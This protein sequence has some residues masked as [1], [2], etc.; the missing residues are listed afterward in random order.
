MA[1]KLP[2][3]IKKAGEGDGVTVSA[4]ETAPA[5]T[6][7]EQKALVRGTPVGEDPLRPKQEPK[8]IPISEAE[9]EAERKRGQRTLRGRNTAG[10]FIFNQPDL[11]PARGFNTVATADAE[12]LDNLSRRLHR[13]LGI[14]G[15]EPG[16][17]PDGISSRLD[18]ATGLRKRDWQRAQEEGRRVNGIEPDS[19]EPTKESTVGTWHERLARVMTVFGHDED[20]LRKHAAVHG[21]SFEDHV[22]GLHRVAQAHYDYLTA[23]NITHAVRDNDYWQHPET[24]ERIKVSENHPDMPEA[25]TRTKGKLASAYRD[26]STMKL[27][28]LPPKAIGWHVKSE[29]DGSRTFYQVKPDRVD[30]KTSEVLPS[31]SLYA[32]LRNEMD[33]VQ[34]GEIK[35]TSRQKHAD[36]ADDLVEQLSGTFRGRTKDEGSLQE[37]THVQGPNVNQEQNEET[38][39]V[40]D[41]VGEE[42]RSG[43]YKGRGATRKRRNISRVPGKLTEEGKVA[44][45]PPR[46]RLTSGRGGV[47]RQ[48][49]PT[50]YMSRQGTPTKPEETVET[51]EVEEPKQEYLAP[52]R[53]L[54]Y[55]QQMI[56][57][58]TPSLKDIDTLR[59]ANIAYNKTLK[60]G[61]ENKARTTKERDLRAAIKEQTGIPNIQGVDEALDREAD[62]ARIAGPKLNPSKPPMIYN[63][64]G[65]ETGERMPDPS[66]ANNTGEWVASPAPKKRRRRRTYVQGD[67]FTGKFPSKQEARKKEL[68]ESL[69]GGTLVKPVTADVQE[70]RK[71]I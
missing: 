53:P 42:P 27:M 18:F 33:G 62:E 70:S 64:K 17:A 14:A 20:T 52:P 60:P 37:G 26:T 65:E 67:L 16:T 15:S 19:L 39:N 8:I 1:E 7:E 66:Y 55:S 57:F 9:L 11:A 22:D 56:R 23:K 38:Y 21:S 45:R 50:P 49:Y 69:G 13:G 36:I 41:V 2:K 48:Q 4:D 63:E 40:Q 28:A 34:A 10:P 35:P 61:E 25:F 58:N 71:R 46:A 68:L 31:F 43:T 29:A 3:G 54:A 24:G 59:Q 44:P 12:N 6:A 47:P 5:A 32:H 51:Q 30:P